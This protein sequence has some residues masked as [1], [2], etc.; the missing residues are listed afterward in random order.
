MDRDEE[1]G[2]EQEEEDGMEREEG[3]GM[4]REEGDGMESDVSRFLQVCRS[5][6]KSTY[7]MPGR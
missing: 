5:H 1:D 2:M 7:H 6:V 4:E 3:D